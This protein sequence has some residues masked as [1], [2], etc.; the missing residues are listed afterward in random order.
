MVSPFRW[1]LRFPDVGT[2]D[3]AWYLRALPRHD[4]SGQPALSQDR[5]YEKAALA[6][7]RDTSHTR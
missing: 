3:L 1:S 4:T 6:T 2:C 7:P 5:N